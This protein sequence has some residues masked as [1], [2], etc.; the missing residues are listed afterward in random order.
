MIRIAIIGG[1]IDAIRLAQYLGHE[2]V[3]YCLFETSRYP[4]SADVVSQVYGA[5]T[6][7]VSALENFEAVVVA[8]HPFDF[9]AV[10]KVKD[11][12]KP[13]L[14]LCRASWRATELDNWQFASN[15]TV[16]AGMLQASGAKRPL[17]AIGRARLTP[18]IKLQ[19]PEMIV[20]CRTK[21]LPDLSSGGIA[22][23][24]PGPFTI[25]QE[26]DFIHSE[27]IDH[28]VAHN[29]GGQGG[30]PKLGAARVLQLPVIL[31]ERPKIAWKAQAED[32]RSVILWLR[33]TVGLDVAPISD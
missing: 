12:V 20:R 26:I 4:S 22:K 7:W 33:Q 3:E 13:C 28:I 30:W 15:E 5:D 2:G 17:L 25:R 16:A 9:E 18:F 11:T 1:S 32:L 6:D 31:I 21:P 19:N 27:R 23:F 24:Q 8:P 10:E 14:A 29:A